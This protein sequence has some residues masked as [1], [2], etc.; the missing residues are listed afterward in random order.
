MSLFGENIQSIKG[1]FAGNKNTLRQLNHG[2]NQIPG[3]V[4]SF[5]KENPKKAGLMAAKGGAVL[6]AGA[7]AAS[8]VAKTTPEQYNAAE[9]KDDGSVTRSRGRTVDRLSGMNGGISSVPRYKMMQQLKDNNLLGVQKDDTHAEADTKL[10]LI[11]G[12][13]AG[14]GAAL[15]APAAMRTARKHATRFAEKN[16]DEGAGI[17]RLIDGASDA[18]KAVDGQDVADAIAEK[19][20]YIDGD[21]ANALAKKY[22]RGRLIGATALGGAAGTVSGYRNGIYEDEMDKKEL[23]GNNNGVNMGIRK[24]S[25]T[26]QSHE[27]EKCAAYLNN[28]K[29]ILG[30]DVD[31]RY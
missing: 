29:N 2:I 12:A 13:A 31:E 16:F 30:G 3:Q 7:L 22:Q 14:L 5:A 15:V 10:G 23:N 17:R 9:W 26:E 19:G 8:Q 11:G 28:V 20:G 24:R 4:K 18:T 21:A 6:G 27:L 25:L 1:L